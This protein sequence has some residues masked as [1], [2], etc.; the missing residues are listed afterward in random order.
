MKQIINGKM[1]NT[2][3]ATLLGEYWNGCSQSDFRF[4]SEDLYRTRKGA[5]F[6]SGEGGAM[7][8]YSQSCGDNSCRGS[9][10]ITPITEDEAKKW[11]EEHCS[12]DDYI[13]AFG[14]PEEA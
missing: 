6:I 14:D 11:L 3:T 2:E 1:Y 12:A 13:A 7:T 10:R 9:E 4:L 5:F 8:E